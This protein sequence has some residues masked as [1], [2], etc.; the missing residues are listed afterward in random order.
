M[1]SVSS[2]ETD[3]CLTRNG[4]TYPISSTSFNASDP[5]YTQSLKVCHIQYIYTLNHLILYPH[6]CRDDQSLTHR[7]I[8]AVMMISTLRPALSGFIAESVPSA[9]RLRIRP[10]SEHTL[11]GPE[12]VSGTIHTP[13][14]TASFSALSSTA[15]ACTSSTIS[16]FHTRLIHLPICAGLKL[17]TM[18]CW[19]SL[20]GSC[21][22][23]QVRNGVTRM[24]SRMRRDV[25]T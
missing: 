19:T 1:I 5:R 2:A 11:L 13:Y 10:A 8:H 17:S 18:I 20:F 25:R 9:G 16:L 4:Y 7:G 22:L 24:M 12:V 23:F 15:L 6:S 21:P 14:S 3:T